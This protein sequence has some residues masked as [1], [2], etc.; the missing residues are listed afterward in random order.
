MKPDL[1]HDQ[2]GANALARYRAVLVEAD[3]TIRRSKQTIE[4]SQELMRELDRLIAGDPRQKSYAAATAVEAPQ[5]IVI[6]PR[7]FEQ[8]LHVVISAAIAEGVRLAV[9]SQASARP[10]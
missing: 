8:L 7:D 1:S 6:I 2:F 9:A 4:K 5:I 10:H 3:E